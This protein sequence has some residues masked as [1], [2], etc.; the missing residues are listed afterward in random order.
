MPPDN[1]APG[2]LTLDLLDGRYAIC[3]LDPAQDVPAWAWSG[4]LASVTR[5]PSE[6]SI[7]CAEAAVPPTVEPVERGWCALRVAGPLDFGMVGVMARLTAPLA[8]AGVS[9]LALATFDTDYLLVRQPDLPCA[10]AALRTAGHHVQGHP[11]RH[12]PAQV[13]PA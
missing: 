10:I 5:T 12:P 4:L 11:E 9:I 13:E 1:P 2:G 3:R 8:E 6:L 7:V